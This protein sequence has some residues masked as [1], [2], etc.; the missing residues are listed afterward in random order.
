MAEKD[1]PIDAEKL[2]R[3]IQARPAIWEA[4]HPDHKNAKMV[5]R[6][7]TEILAQNFPDNDGKYLPWT[8]DALLLFRRRLFSMR[9]AREL[10][11]AR[12]GRTQQPSACGPPRPPPFQ[13]GLVSLLFG[14][15]ILEYV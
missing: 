14:A 6:L 11:R 3:A 9:A 10:R 2:I 5:D 13:P 12:R 7:Y 15:K 8:P 4:C 1:D